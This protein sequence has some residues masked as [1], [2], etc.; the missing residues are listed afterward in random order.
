M[1][2]SH[3]S[4]RSTARGDAVIRSD[5][6]PGTALSDSLRLGQVSCAI[7]FHVGATGNI[8]FK[9]PGESGS[10]VVDSAKWAQGVWHI[11][12]IEQ[13]LATGSTLAATDFELGWSGV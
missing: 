10:R 2:L 4:L 7:L 13:I 9:H 12:Q 3:L 11:V 5:G 6:T 1:T 8:T